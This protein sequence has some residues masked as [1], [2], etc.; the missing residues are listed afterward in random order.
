[1][2]GIQETKDALAFAAAIGNATG[3]V[4]QDGKFDLFE[5]TAYIGAL[6]KFPAAIEGA[7]GI[8]AELQDLTGEE[9][10][11]LLAFLQNELDLP[12]DTTE[13]A[14]EDHLAV[15]LALYRLAQ[16]YYIK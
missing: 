11:E 8:P 12:Q 9:A 14:I 1:M 7:E 16:K 10:A 6:T 15:V 13:E 4:L 2:A 3:V 5:V